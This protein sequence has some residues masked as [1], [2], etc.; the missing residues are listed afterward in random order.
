MIALS[1][2]VLSY[3]SVAAAIQTAFTGSGWFAEPG[4]VYRATD[5][6]LAPAA[7]PGVVGTAAAARTAHPGPLLPAMAA[8]A[9]A[10]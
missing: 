5:L 8:G 10:T 3:Q 4:D 6:L 1:L 9:S 7:R 2:V